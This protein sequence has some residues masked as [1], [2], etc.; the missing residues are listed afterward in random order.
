MPILNPTPLAMQTADK[1]WIVSV[2]IAR[3]QIVAT[4][5]PWDGQFLAG[6]PAQW[7][8]VRAVLA[9]DAGARAA[10]Q[11]VAA[12]LSRAAGRQDAPETVGVQASNPGTR[13]TVL[14]RWA[15]G[16]RYVIP[17][18]FAAVAGDATLAAAYGAMMAWIAGEVR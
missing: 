4:L 5:A 1:L 17:D 10:W 7:R 14:A 16:G 8:T 11:P 13:A 15:D 12:S 3:G 9:D 6:S 2:R 18:L